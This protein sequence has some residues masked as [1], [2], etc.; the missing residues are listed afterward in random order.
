MSNRHSSAL[1]G[2]FIGNLSIKRVFAD[3]N[4]RKLIALDK[5]IESNSAGTALTG[6]NHVVVA[7]PGL[8][9]FQ[10]PRPGLAE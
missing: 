10:G 7:Y 5:G 9:P 2:P 4:T 1:K 8:R 6:P 3:Q